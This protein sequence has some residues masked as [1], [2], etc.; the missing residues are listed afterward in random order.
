MFNQ[1]FTKEKE[2]YQPLKNYLTEQGYVVKGEVRSCDLVAE[3]DGCY[4]TI[5]LKLSFNLKLVFQAVERQE[6]CPNVMLAIPDYAFKPRQRQIITLA[7]KLGMGIITLSLRPSGI[8]VQ[9][10]LSLNV[11][12]QGIDKKLETEFLARSVDFTPSTHQS[13]QTVTVYKEQVLA[14]VTLLDLQGAMSV[15]EIKELTGI[16]KTQTMLAKNYNDYFERIKRGTYQ[17]TEKGKTALSQY[18]AL[19]EFYRDKFR[20]I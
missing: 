10:E 4:L 14:I 1:K 3:R 8:I 5:E 19:T 11:L 20:G 18:H 13:K 6:I 9:E 16:E 7:K 12:K 17:I 15:K 2:L